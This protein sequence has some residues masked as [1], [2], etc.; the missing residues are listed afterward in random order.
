MILKSLHKT[1]ESLRIRVRKLQIRQRKIWIDLA[2]ELLAKIPDSVKELANF[3]N[4]DKQFDE[5]GHLQEWEVSRLPSF[6]ARIAEDSTYNRSTLLT[7]HK[8]DFEAYGFKSLDEL[9]RAILELG[10]AWKGVIAIRVDTGNMPSR[11]KIYFRA[12]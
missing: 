5:S 12:V 4:W 11:A 8:E 1:S 7:I 10:L 6:L 9:E 3:E 2:M